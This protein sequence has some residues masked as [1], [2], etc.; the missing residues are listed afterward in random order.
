MAYLSLFKLFV[1]V[2]LVCSINTQQCDQTSD[3]A[4]FDCYPEPNPTQSQCEARNCC[5]HPDDQ[6]SDTIEIGVPFCYY[7]KDFPSYQVVTNQSTDFGQR[8][9]IIKHQKTYMPNDILDLTVDLI[10]ETQQRLR[11]RIYDSLAK[12][13]EVP[14]DVPTVQNKANV[15]DYA[16]MVQDNPFAIIVKRQSTG[17]VLFDSS[18]SPMIYADQFIKFSTRLSSPFVYGLGEHKQPL[19]LNITSDW[20]R[21]T[22]WSRDVGPQPDTNLYGSIDILVFKKISLMIILFQVSIRFISISN[23]MPI[24]R[25]YFMVNSCSIQMRWMLI[26][27]RYQRLPTQRSVVSLICIFSLVQ[28]HKMSSNSIGM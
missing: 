13:Y 18:V 6:K 24:N 20:Q 25:L 22:F 12:R 16:V 15:T 17:M 4:R 26:F 8:L 21:L 7:S 9:R 27:N 5:W 10:Y 1:V 28:L 11:I 3:N 23:K 14:L 2:C 19:L